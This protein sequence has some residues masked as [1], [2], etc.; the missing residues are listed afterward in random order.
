M[1]TANRNA[2]VVECRHLTA[3]DFDRSI[4]HAVIVKTGKAS[5]FRVMRQ[6]AG[7]YIVFGRAEFLGGSTVV[8]GIDA[9]RKLLMTR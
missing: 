5:N 1:K 6:G 9:V 4:D 8:K 7:V 3:E 2:P